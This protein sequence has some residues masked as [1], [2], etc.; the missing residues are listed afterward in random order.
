MII[1]HLKNVALY[2]PLSPRIALA[3]NY[4]TTTDFSELALGKYEIDGENVFAIVNEYETKDAQDCVLE[5][6]KKYIDI[7]YIV[8]GSEAIGTALLTQQKLTKVYDEQNDYMLFEGETTLQVLT[9]DMFAL[10]YP[11]DIHSPG[12]HPKEKSFVRKVVMKVLHS[13]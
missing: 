5:A 2:C 9:A 7:H 10:L 8:S 6:H 11:Q 3:F 1:D 12:H 4:L 13:C